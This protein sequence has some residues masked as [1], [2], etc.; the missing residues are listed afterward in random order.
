MDMTNIAFKD[1]VLAEGPP[2]NFLLNEGEFCRVRGDSELLFDVIEGLAEPA[3]GSVIV[4]GRNWL[5]LSASEECSHRSNITRML[6]LGQAWIRNLSL[7]ENIGLRA[8]HHR[9]AETA[10]IDG[11]I[12]LMASQLGVDASLDMRPEE[13]T[14]A[15]LQMC[16]WVRAFLA[17]PAIVL[18]Q[19][20]ERAASSASS[21][22]LKK[23]T[24]DRLL[25][26][27]IVFWASE[28]GA[29]T[30]PSEDIQNPRALITIENNEIKLEQ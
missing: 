23:W 20:P 3:S 17:K 5:D 26:G 29:A 15:T 13:L 2:L 12:D 16:Q 24:Q 7:R 25:A 14:P 18:L 30:D 27:G 1:M 10:E 6:P 9:L 11:I 8:T 21:L 4:G 19:D 28:S 22:I